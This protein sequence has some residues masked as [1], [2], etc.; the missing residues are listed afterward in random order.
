VADELDDFRSDGCSAFP[1]GTVSQKMLWLSCCRQHDFT[2]WLGGGSEQRRIADIELR[3]CVAAVGEETIANL[4]LAGVR[5]G[6]SPWWPTSFRWAYGWPYLRG[7]QQIS[8]EEQPMV[9]A[10]VAAAR[11]LIEQ[12]SASAP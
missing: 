11:R 10:K 1:D 6:G 5:V 3:D 7:Y 4:M 2:Y 8:S 9:D 12:A